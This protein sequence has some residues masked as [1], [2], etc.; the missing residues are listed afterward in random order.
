MGLFHSPS[1]VRDGLVLCLDAANPKSYP[2]SGTTWY[3]LSGNNRNFTLYNSSYYS[4][5]SS[6]GFF[7]FNRNLPPDTEIGGYAECTV[8]GPLASTTYL[9]NDHTTEV[10]ARIDNIN[11]TNYDPAST[12]LS[13]ILFAYQGWHAMFHYDTF[14]RYIIWNGTS[15]NVSAP[16]LTVGL[17]NSD[18][19]QGQWFHIT[20]TRNGNT[21]NTYLNGALK[22][23]NSISPSST[24][25]ATGNILRIAMGN[26]PKWPY[27]FLADCSVATIKMYTKSL[28]AAEIAQNFAAHRGR[29]SL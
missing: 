26:I 20:I 4:H 29:Y 27:S 1:I 22:N 15:G 18:I 11:P 9:Y 6:I 10:C 7:D 13:N 12:E 8:S 25:V 24:G 3:D 23:T 5:N 21:M 28:S 14:M 19:N 16:S 2:G 17:S